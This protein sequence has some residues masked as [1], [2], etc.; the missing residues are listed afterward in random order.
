MKLYLKRNQ[1]QG[2]RFCVVDKQTYQKKRPGYIIFP[3]KAEIEIPENDAKILLDQDPH[4]LDTKPLKVKSLS[5]K[6]VL[7][8][9]NTI[10]SIDENIAKLQAKKDELLLQKDQDE[11]KN[12]Q[13]ATS[14]T[15]RS[16]ASKYSVGDDEFIIDEDVIKVVHELAEMENF[17]N[18][19]SKELVRYGKKLGVEIP[20]TVK[21]EEKI[22]M[23]NERCEEIVKLSEKMQ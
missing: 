19:K 5:E 17:N 4:L 12:I 8:I 10:E 15:S 7:E 13:G 3:H 1:P 14:F 2:R 23:L 16:E 9:D 6:Q 21:N 11:N 20:I 18:L 22:K